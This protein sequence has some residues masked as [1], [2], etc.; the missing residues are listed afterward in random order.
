MLLGRSSQAWTLTA[1]ASQIL[2]A[3]GFHTLTRESFDDDTQPK[4]AIRHCLYW[5]FSM[6]K[7]L[8]ML[9]ER[10]ASLPH[11]LL[12]PA[13]LVWIADGNPLYHKAKLLV[14]LGQVQDV[15]LSLLARPVETHAA[16]ISE[17]VR[18]LECELHKIHSSIAEV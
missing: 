11:L 8:S 4:F 17:T 1:I 6:D 16:L 12:E 9:L 15:W 7:M 18:N 5:C 2:V 14:R 13:D 10:P 3:L